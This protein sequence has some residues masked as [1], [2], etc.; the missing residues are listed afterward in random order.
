MNPQNNC[1]RST[2]RESEDGGTYWP[3]D[4]CNILL[5][6]DVRVSAGYIF[7]INQQD[8]FKFNG[9]ETHSEEEIPKK[10]RAGEEI[11]WKAYYLN[12]YAHYVVAHEGWDLCFSSTASK[13]SVY[14]Q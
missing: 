13:S 5:K 10:M 3:W 1:I 11:I 8:S 12:P 6:T 14:I 4:S 9:T 7:D 2:L